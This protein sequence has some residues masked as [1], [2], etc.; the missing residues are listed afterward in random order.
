MSEPIPLT[1][2]WQNLIPYDGRMIILSGLR[3]WDVSS[4]PTLFSLSIETK[5]KGREFLINIV[6][7]GLG[8]TGFSTPIAISTDVYGR[9]SNEDALRV[10]LY[11]KYQPTEQ[12]E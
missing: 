5:D 11:Y 8:I 7:N 1:T 10:E 4:R 6:V 9:A 12:S 3:K 2:E